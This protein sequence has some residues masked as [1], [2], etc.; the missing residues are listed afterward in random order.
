MPLSAD[1][2]RTD[3]ASGA[4]AGGAF[5]GGC[6][7]RLRRAGCRLRPAFGGGLGRRAGLALGGAAGAI[8]D[9]AEQ[10]ADRDGLAILGDDL[11][12]HAGGRRRHFDGD[13]VGL[14]FDQRLVDR[15]GVAGLLEPAADGGLGHGFAERRN[16]D[17]S[18][19]VF[20]SCVM[21]GSPPAHS[22]LISRSCKSR[23]TPAWSTRWERMLAQRLVEERL[24]LRQMLRHQAGGG[25]GRGGAAG[26]ARPPVRRRRSGS[27]THSR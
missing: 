11:A 9:L 22:R 23:R 6:A 8:R 7:A 1:S 13:L 12:E 24:E 16:A 5:G 4:S 18:H 14:Q 21:S 15:H 2:W 27:S 26:I 10:R 17:F 25:R 19:C 3:G 20:P